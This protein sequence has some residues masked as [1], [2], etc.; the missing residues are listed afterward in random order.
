MSSMRKEWFN[1]VAS[2]RK[3][4]QRK[5]K[6]PVS[7]RVAMKEASLVWPKEKAKILNR[8]KRD[9]R[10]RAKESTHNHVRVKRQ[11]LGR[12]QLGSDLGNETSAPGVCVKEKILWVE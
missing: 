11:K 12:A 8:R 7:H 1:F 5:T 6:E 9:E 10:K 2:T 4:M 3:K